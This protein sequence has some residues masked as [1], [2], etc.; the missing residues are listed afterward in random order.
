MANNKQNRSN[1]IGDWAVFREKTQKRIQSPTVVLRK[2]MYAND[3][4]SC[5]EECLILNDRILPYLNLLHT[6]TTAKS[7]LADAVKMAGQVKE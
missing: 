7:F 6:V 5:H 3:H 1:P 2:L 4:D